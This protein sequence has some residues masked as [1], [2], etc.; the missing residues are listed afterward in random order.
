MRKEMKSNQ[1]QKEST[2]RKDGLPLLFSS[3]NIGTLRS[4]P[5][6][7]FPSSSKEMLRSMDYLESL[8]ARQKCSLGAR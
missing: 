3:A 8:C 2:I 7:P 4:K 1:M 5:P 6:W